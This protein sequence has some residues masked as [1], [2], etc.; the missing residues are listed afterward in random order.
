MEMAHPSTALGS[1]IAVEVLRETPMTIIILLAGL[2]SLPSEPYEAAKIDGG[3]TDDDTRLHDSPRA[4]SSA[5]GGAW[6]EWPGRR[7]H[8]GTCRGRR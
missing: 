4:R 2:Q 7:C 6:S 3:G 8:S 1:L 5:A